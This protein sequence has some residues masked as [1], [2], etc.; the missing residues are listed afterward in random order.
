MHK[1]TTRLGRVNTFYCP[2]V[3]IW[4]PEPERR[5]GT[6]SLPTDVAAFLCYAFY[7]AYET[8]LQRELHAET[9]HSIIATNRSKNHS[10][11]HID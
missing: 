4:A 2:D 8:A 7:R 3:C 11:P 10:T 6:S 9:S 5:N 1:N